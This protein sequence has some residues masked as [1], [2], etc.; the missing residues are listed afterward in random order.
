MSDK[1]TATG[2]I[3]V[4]VIAFGGDVLLLKSFEAVVAM[5]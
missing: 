1:T 3:P 2:K 5:I 4:A